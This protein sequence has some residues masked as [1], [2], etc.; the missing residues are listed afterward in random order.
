MLARCRSFITGL[1]AFAV[2]GAIVLNY[3][4]LAAVPMMS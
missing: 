1:V 3:Q 4:A 2:T